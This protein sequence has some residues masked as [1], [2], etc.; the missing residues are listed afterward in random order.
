MSFIDLLSKEQ[1]LVEKILT[2]HD[3]TIS[4]CIS[5][6]CNIFNKI[7]KKDMNIHY[8]EYSKINIPKRF[9]E[10]V[11]QKMFSYFT[12][13]SEYK[14]FIKYDKDITE[15]SKQI[16]ENNYDAI[17][18]RFKFIYNDYWNKSV[19]C[20]ESSHMYGYIEDEYEHFIKNVLKYDYESEYSE[21]EY[22]YYDDDDY[23]EEN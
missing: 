3:V 11:R 16:N 9:D 13:I 6:T 4:K 8:N 22:D 12:K 23:S 20:V 19:S 2:N 15:L 21:L 14:T 10:I 18:E 5:S 1:S 7:V 17:L